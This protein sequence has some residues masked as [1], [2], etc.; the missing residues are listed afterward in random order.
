M[1]VGEEKK[2]E[3]GL[4]GHSVKQQ[5]IHHCETNKRYE[6]VKKALCLQCVCLRLLNENSRFVLSCN[7]I[8]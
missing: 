4:L 7:A 6:H 3:K 5:F 1:G 8:F 2:I